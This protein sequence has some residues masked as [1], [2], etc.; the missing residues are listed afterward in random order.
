MLLGL[1]QAQFVARYILLASG[2]TPNTKLTGGTVTLLVC[3]KLDVS[4]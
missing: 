4:K 3:C 2:L 1:P